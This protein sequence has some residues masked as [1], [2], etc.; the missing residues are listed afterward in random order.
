MST[1]NKFLFAVLT[2]SIQAGTCLIYA[3]IGEILAERSGILNLGVEGMMLVGALTA[4]TVAF[5]TQN[6]LVAVILAMIAGG[7]MALIHA[8][9]SIKFRADQNVSGLALTIFGTGLANFLGRYLGPNGS[10][11][12]GQVAPHLAKMPIPGLADLPFVGRIFFHHDI[13]V[14]IMYMLV[15]ASW[16]YLYK[17]WPGLNLRAIGENP[18]AVDSLGINVFRL[19]YIYTAIGGMLA[20]LAGAHLSLAYS[21]GWSDN[22]TAGRG[23]IVIALTIFATW[24]PVRGLFGALLFGSLSILQFSIQTI[25]RRISGSILNMMPYILTIGVLV[26]ITWWEGIRKSAGTPQALGIP[27]SREE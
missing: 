20:G 17:T 14:Y 2:T 7:L 9:L 8:L 15:A 23:W 13:L 22:M 4:F 1:T 24:N 26:I 10:S 25:G 21:P 19:R 12:V 18:Q 11:L 5:Y 16:F 3:T 6:L 27:Y